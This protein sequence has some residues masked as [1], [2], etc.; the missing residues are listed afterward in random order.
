[1]ATIRVP[2]VKR[3]IAEHI[4][5]TVQDAKKLRG[6]LKEGSQRVSV[7]FLQKNATATHMDFKKCAYLKTPGTP[8]RLPGTRSSI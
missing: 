8:V 5:D 3:L 1:M 7:R 4:V 6:L 2:S